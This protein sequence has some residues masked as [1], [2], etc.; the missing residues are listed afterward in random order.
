MMLSAVE[1][2]VLGIALVLFL[3]GLIV[4]AA[5]SGKAWSFSI[6]VDPTRKTLATI[7]GAVSMVLG[8]ALGVVAI[9]GDPD[10]E[11]TPGTDAP[12]TTIQPGSSATTGDTI[13]SS[14]TSGAVRNEASLPVDE[15]TSTVTPSPLRKLGQDELTVTAT[16]TLRSGPGCGGT[17]Y[18]IPS[19]THDGDSATAWSEGVDGLGQGESLQFSFGVEQRVVRVDL[20]P[21]WQRGET[22]L[23]QRNGRPRELLLRFDSGASQTVAVPDEATLLQIPVDAVTSSM[24]IQILE[25]WPGSACGGQEPDEDTLITE[26]S[27]F[28]E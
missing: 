2:S 4:L 16:S 27:I 6:T 1:S 25:V 10:E 20:L 17:C 12:V 26:V 19:N 21:G 23:F 8:V 24:V 28:V 9:T 22:C 13:A 5:S 15:T 7:G 11:A 14:T 3:A 18:F